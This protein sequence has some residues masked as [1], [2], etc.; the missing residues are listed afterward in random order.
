MVPGPLEPLLN[1]PN[2]IG[3]DGIYAGGGRGAGDE[4][5]NTQSRGPGGGGAAQRPDGSTPA[6]K[7][8]GINGT[9]GGGGGAGGGPGAPLAGPGGDGIVIIRYAA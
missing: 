8:A 1:A 5:G 9:G 6:I 7:M 3:P 2:A 4:S